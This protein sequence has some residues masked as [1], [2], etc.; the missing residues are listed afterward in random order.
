MCDSL[1]E[2]RIIIIN[3]ERQINNIEYNRISLDV[4]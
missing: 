4:E 1:D 2:W 3:V